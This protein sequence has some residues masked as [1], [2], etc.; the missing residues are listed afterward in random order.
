MIILHS[1]T[2]QAIYY[3][4]KTFRFKLSAQAQPQFFYRTVLKKRND[5]D[6]EN[7]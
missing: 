5:H 2:S 7:D 4:S 1:G 6:E 3:S